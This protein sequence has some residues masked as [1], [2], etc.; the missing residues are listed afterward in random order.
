MSE[1]GG[2]IATVMEK[3]G[4]EG[5]VAVEDSNTIGNSYE[6]VEG[7]QFDRGYVSQYMVSEP[8]KNGSGFGRA[9]YFSDRQ[10]NIVHPGCFAHYLKRSW[11]AG[12]RN[13]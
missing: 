1:I 10:K 12:K 4:K 6:I 13:S 5:V 7:M 2:L 11:R 3:I 8:G 9:V